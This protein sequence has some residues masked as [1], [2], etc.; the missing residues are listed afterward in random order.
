MLVHPSL[1]S[2]SG[3]SRLLWNWVKPKV[4]DH[5]EWKPSEYDGLTA[6]ARGAFFIA[7]LKNEDDTNAKYENATSATNEDATGAKLLQVPK[8]CTVPRSLYMLTDFSTLQGSIEAPRYTERFFRL[9]DKSSV[10]V[11]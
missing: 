3:I 6:S 2:P 4:Y 5:L 11:C 9:N 8:V 10:V 7:L 1:P